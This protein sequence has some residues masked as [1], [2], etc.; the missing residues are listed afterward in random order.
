MVAENGKIL[1][2]R[3]KM[4][5]SM[6]AEKSHNSTVAKNKDGDVAVGETLSWLNASPK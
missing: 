6:L 4:T 1:K 2:K 5:K 3:P